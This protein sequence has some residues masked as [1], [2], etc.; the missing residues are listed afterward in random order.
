MT[1]SPTVTNQPAARQGGC[2][3]C[4]VGSSW[5]A[6]HCAEVHEL[7]PIAV[8][9]REHSTRRP[10]PCAGLVKGGENALHRPHAGAEI[11]NRQAINRAFCS[12]KRIRFTGLIAKGS[13]AAE[14]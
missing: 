8:S 2:A 1:S 4:R 10:L 7:K 12:S 9:N 13:D 6:S 11:A 14:L 3:P 5:S